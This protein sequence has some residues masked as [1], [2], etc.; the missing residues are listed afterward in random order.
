VKILFGEMGKNLLTEG[1]HVIP[2]RLEEQG[3]EFTH[4]DLESALRDTLGMWT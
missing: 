3:Y 2:S 1:Q 4:S